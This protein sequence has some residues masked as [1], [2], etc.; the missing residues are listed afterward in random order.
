[1]SFIQRSKPI[2]LSSKTIWFWN[3]ELRTN[4]KCLVGLNFEDKKFENDGDFWQGYRVYQ[5]SRLTMQDIFFRVTFE[6]LLKQVVFP[7]VAG[8]VAKIGLSLN[9][10]TITKLRLSK[11][12]IHTVDMNALNFRKT[13]IDSSRVWIKKNLL[14]TVLKHHKSNKTIWNVTTLHFFSCQVESTTYLVVVVTVKFS[15]A[16]MSSKS[17]ECDEYKKFH[18]FL[19]S[20]SP[21]LLFWKC[22]KKVQLYVLRTLETIDQIRTQL[23][24]FCVCYVW[25]ILIERNFFA[26]Q[27]CTS[28]IRFQI[29]EKYLW[30][31]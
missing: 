27:G 14:K 28:N 20:S 24:A 16:E 21:F 22:E 18:H 2:S 9:Q 15:V 17:C 13:W 8:A 1:M 30:F 19:F 29:Y 5:R 11:S 26:R 12:L 3:F 23:V 25:H 31:E 10:T 4:D 7:E 6:S